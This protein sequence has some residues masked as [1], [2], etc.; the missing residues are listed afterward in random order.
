MSINTT[1]LAD[2]QIITMTDLVK[3]MQKQPVMNIG[4]IGHVSNGKSEIVKK[5]TG[6]ATQKHS[7]EKKRGITIRTGYANAK[8]FKCAKC[9]EPI[10]YQSTSSEVTTYNCKICKGKTE[11]VNHVSFVDNPGHHSFMSTMM[12]GTSVMDCSILVESAENYIKNGTLPAPQTIEHYEIT[13]QV[14]IPTNIVCMN[15]FDLVQKQKACDFVEEMK[16]W[17]DTTNIDKKMTIIPISATLECNLDVLCEKIAKIEKPIRD[18]D[19]NFRMLIIRSF[20]VNQP[21]EK[22][23]NLKGGV[24]GGT[25]TRGIIKCGDDVNIFPGYITSVNNKWE[26]KP[27]QSKIMSINSD[28]TPLTEAISGGLIGIQLDIDPAIGCSDKLVGQMIVPV[29]ETE[30]K[31]Y[32]TIIVN[33]FKLDK[34]KEMD[35]YLTTNLMVNINSNNIQCVLKERKENNVMTFKLKKP[36]A[37]FIGDKLTLSTGDQMMTI[38]GYGIINDGFIDQNF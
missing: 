15:K 37:V 10:C 35:K 2:K 32:D 8:I 9:I 3:I 23:R 16:K 34:I 12:N 5:M 27:L 25:L 30:V 18:V 6:T 13:N 14:G 38:I 29:T 17:I 31:V 26:Y 36:V 33:F 1:Q 21:R 20:N 22:I 19:S 28:K 7:G 11:L 24:V 4:M